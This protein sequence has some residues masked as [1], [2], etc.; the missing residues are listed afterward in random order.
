MSRR[1]PVLVTLPRKQQCDLPGSGPVHAT[2]PVR[3]SSHKPPRARAS[4]TAEMT[5]VL[6]G[7]EKYL[8]C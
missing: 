7:W 8:D 2:L 3:A 4:K 6:A 1:I 5:G